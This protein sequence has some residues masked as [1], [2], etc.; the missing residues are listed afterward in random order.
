MEIANGSQRLDGISA[1]RRRS[2]ASEYLGNKQ[3][4]C[5]GKKRWGDTAAPESLYWLWLWYLAHCCLI[6]HWCKICLIDVPVSISF[7]RNHIFVFFL[8][9][10]PSFPVRTSNALQS[11]FIPQHI[12][13]SCFLSRRECAS[14][15]KEREKAREGGRESERRG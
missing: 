4:Q 7:A 5:L 14:E 13:D 6:R 15:R 1:W 8:C 2:L 11:V 3:A 10:W 9:G 12:T